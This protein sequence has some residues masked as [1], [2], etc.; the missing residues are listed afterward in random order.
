LLPE[1]LLPPRGD[2]LQLRR[3]RGGGELEAHLIVAF[4]RRAVRHGIGVFCASDLDHA[5]C[6]QRA[7]NRGAE[8]ILPFIDRARLDHREDEIACEFFSQIVDVAFARAG[9]ERLCIE[10]VELLLLAHIGAEGDDFAE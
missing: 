3:E 6:D 5:L 10:A 4:A 8:E 1:T 9:A 2:D 7:G